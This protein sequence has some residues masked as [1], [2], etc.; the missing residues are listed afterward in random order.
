MKWKRNAIIAAFVVFIIVLVLLFVRRRENLESGTCTAEQDEIDGKCYERCRE[1]FSA[2]G[3]NCYEIC[4]SGEKSEGLSCISSDGATRSVTSYSR[5]PIIA[6]KNT[7]EAKKEIVECDDGYEEFSGF[8]MEKCKDG[9]TRSGFMCM[10]MCPT[11]TRS[12]GIMC[13]D[14]TKTMMKESYFSNSKFS[15]N[16][17]TSNV[18]SCPSHYSMN[19]AMCIEDCPP[20]H[21]LKGAFCIEKCASGETDLETMCLNGQALRKKLIS[22]PRIS[23]VPIKT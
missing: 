7:N 22:V 17:N 12:L 11:G 14:N 19:G 18:L 9:F 6:S 23:T 10:G 2:V 15:K 1:G 20:N 8:C 3:E 4:K 13:A 16:T 21:E 5:N